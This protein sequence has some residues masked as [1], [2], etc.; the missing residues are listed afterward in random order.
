MQYNYRKIS[1][2]INVQSSNNANTFNMKHEIP[3]PTGWPLCEYYRHNW[4]KESNNIKQG[5]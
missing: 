2:T 3:K 5:D 4:V 1:M